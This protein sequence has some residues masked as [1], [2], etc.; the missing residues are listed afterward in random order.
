MLE[1]LQKPGRGN[2]CSDWCIS[3]GEIHLVT[4]TNLQVMFY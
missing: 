4:L 3:F 2:Y 1:R